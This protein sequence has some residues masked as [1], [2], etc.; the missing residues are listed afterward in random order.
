MH[1]S[2]LASAMEKH[3][4]KVADDDR[5]VLPG[6]LVAEGMATYFIT[7]PGPELDGWRTSTDPIKRQLAADW[8]RHAADMPEL[9]AMAEADIGR[10]LDGELTV[11]QLVERWLGGMQGP[12]YAVGMDMMRLIDRELGQATV[13]GLARDSRP[14]LE[15]Y[16][17]AARSARA[18]GESAYLFAEPL[19]TRLAAF[20]DAS[21]NRSQED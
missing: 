10:G 15:V 11:D 20:R 4:G 1:H 12:A 18:H 17:R 7:P 14:L 8:D 19:A 3:M 16:N 13:I 6:I 5:I 2:G 9:Y 21:A